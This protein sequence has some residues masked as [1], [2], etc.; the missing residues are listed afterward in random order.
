[1]S[2]ENLEKEQEIT[3]QKTDVKTDVKDAKKEDQSRK[4]PQQRR[5]RQQLSRPALRQTIHLNS[6]QAH[7][8][9]DYSFTRVSNSLFSTDVILQIIGDPDDVGR[10]EEAIALMIEKVSD[11]LLAELERTKKVMTDNGIM[12]IPEYTEPKKYDIE[13][14]SPQIAS[15]ASLM[16]LLDRLMSQVDALW[17]HGAFTN[18]QRSRATFEWQQRLIRL[19]GRI[20]SIEKEARISA[21]K[22]GKQEEVEK[23]APEAEVED[24]NDELSKIANEDQETEEVAAHVAEA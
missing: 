24:E 9:I 14:T 3:A 20:I 22:R 7:N 10:L 19:A 2:G 21:Y 6:L 16:V 17:L 23:A 11:E 8:V 1:M 18:R 13:I 15:F 4:A 5:V 12:D